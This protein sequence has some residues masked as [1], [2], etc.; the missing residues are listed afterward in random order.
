MKPEQIPYT[1]PS[2]QIYDSGNFPKILEKSLEF[3]D[4]LGFKQRKEE[5]KQ[6]GLLRGIGV[7]N[8]LE[9]TA[10]VETEMG[11]IRFEDNGDVTIITGTLDYGQGTLSLLLKSFT[12]FLGYHLSE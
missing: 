9:V 4:W 5:S 7:S 11:G 10:P 1:A 3:S 2:G 6:R 12:V 8:Y